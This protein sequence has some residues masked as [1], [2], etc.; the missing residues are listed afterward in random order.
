MNLIQKV[1]RVVE[2]VTVREM[3][4]VA[5]TVVREMAVVIRAEVGV[6]LVDLAPAE[7]PGQAT[8]IKARQEATAGR[9]QMMKIVMIAP[10]ALVAMPT[11]PA[12]A[13]VDPGVV[14]FHEGVADRMPH[15][16]D[17]LHRQI[18]PQPLQP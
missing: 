8:V 1:S 12:R 2:E 6:A 13:L 7:E 9:L 17:Q 3:A 11:R 4:V 5:V 14:A 15:P 10:T 18:L 16:P